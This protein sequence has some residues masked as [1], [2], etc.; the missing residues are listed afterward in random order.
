LR[1]ARVAYY[2]PLPVRSV[3]SE[4]SAV[5]T[6]NTA[7]MT[8]RFIVDAVTGATVRAFVVAATVHRY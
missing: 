2:D 5:K 4:V 1:D 6:A 7:S 8:S 3:S